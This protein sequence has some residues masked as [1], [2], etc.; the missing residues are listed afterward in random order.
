[1]SDLWPGRLASPPPPACLHRPRS[2]GFYEIFSRKI[3]NKHLSQ[4][5]TVEMYMGTLMAAALLA[6]GYLFG[7]LI[8]SG[9]ADV[10]KRRPYGGYGRY[11]DLYGR[12]NH[13]HFAA[14]R[15]QRIVQ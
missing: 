11:Y 13:P 8:H 1:M 4:P 9:L 3:T 15:E 2:R 10:S 5:V 14:A 7:A 12:L 6:K